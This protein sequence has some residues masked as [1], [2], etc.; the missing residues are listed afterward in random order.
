MVEGDRL[1]PERDFA[2]AR[3]RRGRDLDGFELAILDQLQC[4]HIAGGTPL[5][6]V[7]EHRNDPK[8]GFR[9][10]VRCFSAFA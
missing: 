9:F 1:D 8:T 3:R 2:K 5:A 6:N 10:S 7:R 4:A